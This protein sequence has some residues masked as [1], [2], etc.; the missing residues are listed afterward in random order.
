[1]VRAVAAPYQ[2]ASDLRRSRFPTTRCE[3]G[4]TSFL[5]GYVS[6]YAS[7]KRPS[8]LVGRNSAAPNLYRERA[9]ARAKAA[10]RDPAWRAIV[11]F[12]HLAR[13]GRMTV[14][15]GRRELLVALGGA[16]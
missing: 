10:E 7:C 14:T 12:T 4:Q 6:R 13:E 8:K 16:A 3:D 2:P 15:I 9:I 11:P 1:M 5:V